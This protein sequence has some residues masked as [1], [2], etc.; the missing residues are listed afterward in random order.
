MSTFAF[1]LIVIGWR[2]DLMT[3]TP[4]IA[5]EYEAASKN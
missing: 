3:N 2:N 1:G 5:K 4:N